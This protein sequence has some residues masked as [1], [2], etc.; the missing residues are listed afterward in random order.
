MNRWI[1]LQL[2][3][4]SA[5][6]IQIKDSL[7]FFSAS[8]IELPS[9]TEIHSPDF[10][11]N[12]NAFIPSLFGR[13]KRK[14]ATWRCYLEQ[15]ISREVE[16]F[17]ISPTARLKKLKPGRCT[18]RT[19]SPLIFIGYATLQHPGRLDHPNSFV[20][21]RQYITSV[22]VGQPK[23]KANADA[24]CTFMTV[25]YLF[26]LVSFSQLW[27]YRESACLI[28]YRIHTSNANHSHLWIFFFFEQL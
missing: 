16:R 22:S 13:L 18:Q 25:I 27:D 21:I 6:L 8:F 5:R 24:S 28:E 10:T 3:E 23:P 7:G 20:F 11:P 9:L 12:K 19:A 1:L 4:C 26:M 17:G 15:K 2:P 14:K